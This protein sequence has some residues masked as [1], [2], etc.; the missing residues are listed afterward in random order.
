MRRF[1]WTNRAVRCCFA[2]TRIR[3]QK[4][5]LVFCSSFFLTDND[6]DFSATAA[7]TNNNILT[8]LS[9]SPEK[10]CPMNSKCQLIPKTHIDAIAEYNKTYMYIPSCF[11]SREKRTASNLSESRQCLFAALSEHPH[12]PQPVSLTETNQIYSRFLSLGNK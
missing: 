10:D 5:C 8:S 4:T 7:A 9:I 3:L 1:D 11:L 12:H 6:C 2:C